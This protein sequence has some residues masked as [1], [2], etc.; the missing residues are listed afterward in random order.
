MYKETYYLL[1]AKK[2]CYLF[3][4]VSG[5]FHGAWGPF[6]SKKSAIRVA[7]QAPSHFVSFVNMR[8]F[9]VEM[10]RN[11]KHCVFLCCYL[12]VCMH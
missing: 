2:T 11:L 12:H 1:D 10:F 7:V 4:F 8:L 5:F 3:D 6:F 9:G